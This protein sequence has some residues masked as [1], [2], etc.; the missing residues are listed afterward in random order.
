MQ[1]VADG[2]PILPKELG[3]SGL[4]VIKSKKTA[5]YAGTYTP[6]SGTPFSIEYSIA[7]T[8][9][10]NA[11]VSLTFKTAA[12]VEK[13]FSHAGLNIAILRD[14]FFDGESILIDGKELASPSQ[15]A[16]EN[17]VVI[18]NGEAS[19]IVYFADDPA[20]RLAL[21]VRN[22]GTVSVSDVPVVGLEDANIVLHFK[23]RC[24]SASTTA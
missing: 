3:E 5:V 2:A 4:D 8:S 22:A 20:R 17:P 19:A 10:D 15:R 6:A 23:P 11:R 18:Y 16:G 14:A 21:T 24:G 9:E 13:I 7:L 1:L 12:P